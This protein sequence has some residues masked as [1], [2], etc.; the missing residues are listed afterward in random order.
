MLRRKVPTFRHF[1][2]PE[3]RGLA[4]LEPELQER[5]R[6]E[7]VRLEPEAP[8]RVVLELGQ[9]VQEPLELDILL[10]R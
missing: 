8:V 4:P 5:V 6:L 9:P 1:E 10:H 7:R 2:G 3:R